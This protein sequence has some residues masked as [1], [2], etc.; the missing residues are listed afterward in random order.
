[1]Q[2]GGVC[3]IKFEVFYVEAVALV[4][5]LFVVQQL[6]DGHLQQRDNS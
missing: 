1:M 6:L 4:L 3:G 5:E 2:F